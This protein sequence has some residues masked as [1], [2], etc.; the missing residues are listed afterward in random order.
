ML[1]QWDFATQNKKKR[2][3]V[4]CERNCSVT[5]AILLFRWFWFSNTFQFLFKILFKR[6]VPFWRTRPL[7]VCC[8]RL[9]IFPISAVFTRVRTVA[10]PTVEMVMFPRAW[11][12][13]LTLPVVVPRPLPVVAWLPVRWPPTPVAAIGQL[14]M[15]IFVFFRGASTAWRPVRFVWWPSAT[16][17]RPRT[18]SLPLDR[19]PSSIDRPTVTVARV[20]SGI[21]TAVVVA[22]AGMRLICIVSTIRGA[23]S[24][25]VVLMPTTRCVT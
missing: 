20:A 5:T 21:S 16:L 11:T 6:V 4:N 14:R 15:S 2:K 12:V 10:A 17:W 24:L 18:S 19:T 1:L 22:D 23:C 3:C 25:L 13:A 7:T 9:F 8:W